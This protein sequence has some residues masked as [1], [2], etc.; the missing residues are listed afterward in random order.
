MPRANLQNQLLRREIRAKLIE[1]KNK[2]N[3]KE[4]G[5]TFTIKTGRKIH[6]M[7]LK[8]LETYHVEVLLI[9]LDELERSQIIEEIEAKIDICEHIKFTKCGS[10]PANTHRTVP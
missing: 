7:R 2:R 6:I 8:I 10:V 5:T 1:F 4:N 3:R 9:I